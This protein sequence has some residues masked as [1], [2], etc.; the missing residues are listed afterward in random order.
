MSET[1]LTRQQASEAVTGH[2]WRFVLGSLCT[3]VEV[4]SLA[5]A[6]EVAS[7]AVA[8]A[9]PGAERHLLL[10]LRGDRV[11]LT[12]QVPGEMRVTGRET[13]LAVRVSAA[14]TEAGHTTDAV[15]G[16]QRVVQLLEIA[17]DALDIAAVR[18]FWLAVL[19]YAE[20][21]DDPGAAVVDP[22]GQGPTVWFQQM[23][24]PRTQRNRIHLDIS[25]PHDEADRRVAAAVAA[26]GRVVYDKE[27][28]AFRVLA[29]PE[30]NEVCVTTWLGRD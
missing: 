30:G 12:V 4:S 1:V 18:P 8:A 28:P 6:A 29:D 26:G 17:I 24:R 21:G 2:G 19:G 25:V 20:V 14:L 13:E 27:A 7:L 3:A 22:Y 15:G 11:L 10:D 9:G 5:Q 23:D 16:R